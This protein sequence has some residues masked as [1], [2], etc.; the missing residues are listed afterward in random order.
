MSFCICSSAKRSN[1]NWI[2]FGNAY[3]QA[4]VASMTLTFVAWNLYVEQLWWVSTWIST[5]N[6]LNR[7]IGAANAQIYVVNP[8]TLVTGVFFC[9]G[10]ARKPVATWVQGERERQKGGARSKKHGYRTIA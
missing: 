9:V 8:A 1:S 6:E 3:G 4:L 10:F 7:W 2:F 5:V